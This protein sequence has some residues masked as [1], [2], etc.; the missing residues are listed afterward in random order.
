MQTLARLFGRSPFAPLQAHM[1]K[2][3]DCVHAL[4]E[5][6]DLLQKGHHDEME[7]IAARISKMEHD[8][9]LAKNDIRNHLPSNLFLPINRS[10][11]LELLSLQDSIADRAEDIAILMTLKALPVSQELSPLLQAFIKKNLQAVERAAEIISEMD[12]LLESSFG[13]SEA[14][15]VMEM[16]DQVALFEHECDVQQRGL[17][18]HFFSVQDNT[19]VQ[20]FFLWM[21]VIQELGSLADEAEKL[22]NRVRMLLEVK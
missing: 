6:F 18:K 16:V 12:K 14:N 1:D 13:G 19:D 2:V 20:T 3:M 15:K 17:L 8:A 9:D 5:M 11:L 7:Q 22:A 4:V 10:A 21:R